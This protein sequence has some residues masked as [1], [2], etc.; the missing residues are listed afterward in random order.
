ML[1][2]VLLAAFVLGAVA[3]DQTCDAV[4]MTIAGGPCDGVV[5][6]TK[7]CGGKSLMPG[8]SSTWVRFR[9]NCETELC[10]FGARMMNAAVSPGISN[11]IAI[12]LHNVYCERLTCHVPSSAGSVVWGHVRRLSV[13]TNGIV[14]LRRGLGNSKGFLL[15][16]QRDIL[17]SHGRRDDAVLQNRCRL[18]E[19]GTVLLMDEEDLHRCLRWCRHS[20][21]GQGYQGN[22]S[23]WAV[24][25][26]C[27]QCW[28]RNPCRCAI[29]T[30]STRIDTCVDVQ[31]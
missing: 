15:Q 6:P 3:Q 4:S 21:P 14:P 28:P 27:L 11:S 24:C 8:D 25:G 23:G 19:L 18:Q 17:L 9:E 13:Q 2:C 31:H 5:A 16:R 7:A 1:R 22:Q 10:D 12:A 20:S 26:Y 30:S 29:P